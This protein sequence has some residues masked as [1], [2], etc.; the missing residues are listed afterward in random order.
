MNRYCANKCAAATLLT[1]LTIIACNVWAQEAP[2]VGESLD[3][4]P[5]SGGS[6]GNFGPFDYLSDKDKLPVVEN[7][8]FTPRVEQL[9]GGET[10]QHAIG[11]VSYTLVKFPNHHRALYSAVRFSLEDMGGGERRSYPAECFLQRAIYF[12]P[13]DAVP[14][15]L[16]G[17]YLH[18]LGQLEQS[19]NRYQTA[20]E[21]A[22]MDGNLLYNIGL[23]HFEIGNYAQAQEY[24]AKAYSRGI[25][26]PGLRRKLQQ[27]GHWK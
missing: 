10:T 1:L 3:G 15:M 8:H 4:N 5:C 18:R 11:D 21:L 9:Q 26:L 19:L 20:E 7:R 6:A 16:Y 17:L 13:R 14:H 27:A 12:S 23:V 22:P 24:A 25:T 2:W